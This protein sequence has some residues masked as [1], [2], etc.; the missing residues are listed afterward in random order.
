VTAAREAEAE[1]NAQSA[2]RRD[3]AEVAK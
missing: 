1:R 2:P 3:V